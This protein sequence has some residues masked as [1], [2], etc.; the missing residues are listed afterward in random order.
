MKR[1]LITGGAGFIGHQFVEYLLC[2]TDWRI[3]VMDCLTYSGRLDRL[4]E[5]GALNNERVFT[6]TSNFAAE[7]SGNVVS[8]VQ[9]VDTIFHLGAETHVD[10]SIANPEPFVTA[11]V[12]GT[13]HVL[14][15]ARRVD[16]LA[17]FFYFGTDE[18]FGPAPSGVSYGEEDQHNPRNP[19]AATKSGGEMLVKA[20]GNTFGIPFV[21]TRTMNVF[22]ERQHP[23]KFIPSTIRKVL[24]GDE[25]TIHADATCMIPGSRAY[26]HARDVANAYVYL[27]QACKL[28]EEYHIAGDYEIDN[29]ALAGFIAD[30][31]GR[32]LRY[33]MVDFHS[34]RPGH[35]LR[36]SLSSSKLEALGWKPP[37]R[38]FE[39]LEDTVR[40]YL[41][42]PGW[43]EVWRDL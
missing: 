26:I 4:R 17:C 30:C 37:G 3:V 34:S 9:D 20:Y 13:M 15:L 42:N 29:L 40:W 32:P 24:R 33:R 27:T 35:D 11:N 39:K 5:I 1:V 43:L 38:L 7:L 10:R 23:E 36:Y 18:V 8:E 6:L 41:A 14:N 25:V 2:N 12:L 16:S 28:G 31:I 22:G 21:I 19:Y